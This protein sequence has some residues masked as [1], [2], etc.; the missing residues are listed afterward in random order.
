VVKHLNAREMEAYL[1][2]NAGARVFIGRPDDPQ[3]PIRDPSNSA[4]A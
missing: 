1:A 3:P 4:R 2:E